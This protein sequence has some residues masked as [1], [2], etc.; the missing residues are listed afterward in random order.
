M[1]FHNVV[2]Y[3][4]WIFL[5]RRVLNG[6]RVVFLPPGT[7]DDAI[8]DDIGTPNAANV[9]PKLQEKHEDSPNVVHALKQMD[10]DKKP[11]NT[12]EDQ[13]DEAA[14]SAG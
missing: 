7:E 8:S 14:V 1:P 6:N 11:E 3:F 10:A 9:E 5:A 4:G 13:G 12:P 2:Q